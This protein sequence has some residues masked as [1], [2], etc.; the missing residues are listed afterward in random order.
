M[1]RRQRYPTFKFLFYLN[2][3]LKHAKYANKF[4]FKHKIYHT[5][6]TRKIKCVCVCMWG[7]HENEFQEIAILVAYVFLRE[8]ENK[9]TVCC[10]CTNIISTRSII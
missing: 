3:V 4:W 2:S 6:D 1:S 5:N 7:D 8:L 10:G 9:K